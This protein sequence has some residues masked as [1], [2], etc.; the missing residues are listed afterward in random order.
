MA[1]EAFGSKLPA[2]PECLEAMDAASV[3]SAG[4]RDEEMDVEE[5]RPSDFSTLTDMSLVTLKPR[6][7]AGVPFLAVK[8][9]GLQIYTNFTP[10]DEDWLRLP[11]G[12]STNVYKT[13]DGKTFES[14]SV[15]IELSEE[16]L[17]V[18]SHLDA[19]I[20][21]EALKLHPDKEW[22]AALYNDLLDAALVVTTDADPGLDDTQFMVK[23]P[24][25]DPVTGGGAEFVT[26]MMKGNNNFQHAKVKLIMVLQKVWLNEKK[27]G[28]NWKVTAMMADVQPRIK[29]SWPEAFKADLF[30]KK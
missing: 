3:T 27:M 2:D 13:K 9:D 24:G 20:K 21:D 7:Y 12:I 14:F 30:K 6:T 29:R 25:K 26:N 19:K 18:V 4:K 5:R 16:L 28:V 8:Y 22:K 23:V 17:T 1:A 15:R 10:K 11:F